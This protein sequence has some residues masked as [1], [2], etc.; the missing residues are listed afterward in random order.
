LSR[1][2][3]TDRNEAAKP[4]VGKIS[5]EVFEHLI[6]PR[7]GRSRES[8]LVGP[9]AGCDCA[10]IDLGGGQVLAAT[11]DP[12]FI[13]PEFGWDRA[14]WFAIHIVASDAATSG[15]APAYCTLDLNLPLELSDGDLKFL[16]GGID[17]SCAQAGISIVAGHTGRYEGCA[18]PTVGS[19]T[20]LCTG[21][22]D[23]YVT[24]AMA[25]VGDA[26]LM[27]KGAAIETTA[28]FGVGFPEVLEAELGAETAR[29]AG[30]LFYAM[31]VVEDARVAVQAGV[32]DRG[33]SSMHDATERGV[34]GAL[35]EMANASDV[36]LVVDR[37]AVYLPPEVRRVCDHFDIDPYITSSEGT[38]LIA[39]HPRVSKDIISRLEAASI[40]AFHIAEM[41][42]PDEGTRVVI[43][44]RECP[45][46]MPNEDPFWP[47]FSRLRDSTGP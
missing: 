25:K 37:D 14:T 15:L 30:N 46:G 17:A 4:S 24:P 29:A 32:R 23:H 39:C 19:A 9:R 38:L 2:L 13:M 5:A 3:V 22:S 33:V 44:G 47:A 42:P 6:F 7:L 12:L 43:D 18:F 34:W 26:I 10:I 20:V 1:A 45:L 40:P 35:I 28:L 31:S 36:G 41:T 11:T 16:W 21:P 8:V 27:T